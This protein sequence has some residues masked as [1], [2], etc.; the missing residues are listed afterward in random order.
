MSF[1]K[2]AARA[3]SA[4]LIEQGIDAATGI[5]PNTSRR[6]RASL[7]QFM[8]LGNLAGYCQKLRHA[9]ANRG[10]RCQQRVSVGMPRVLE[11]LLDRPFFN[12]TACIHHIDAITKIGDEAKIVGDEQNCGAMLRALRAI[13]RAPGPEPLHRAQ[14]SVHRQSAARARVQ[15]PWQSWHAVAFPPKI[16]AD[17]PL[18][19]APGREGAQSAVNRWRD[20]A[21]P[22]R[23]C[24]DAEQR[25]RRPDRRQ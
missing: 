13:A 10:R 22:P 7:R 6:K 20:G 2:P 3:V 18:P 5:C 8:R 12:H 16:D 4:F 21:P 23:R 15:G 1:G 17:I 24:P 11:N 19:A 9:L 14:W 25:V